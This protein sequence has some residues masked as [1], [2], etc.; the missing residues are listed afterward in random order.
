M[1][2][3]ITLLFCSALICTAFAQRNNYHKRYNNSVYRNDNRS[4]ERARE[5]QRINYDYNFK[6]NQVNYN[7]TLRRAQKRRAIKTLEKQRAFEIRQASARY[8]DYGYRL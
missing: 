5:I 7:P 8:N 6:I 1:K 2:K 3:L 4:N